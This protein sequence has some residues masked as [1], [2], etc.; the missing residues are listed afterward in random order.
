MSGTAKKKFLVLFLAP[1]QVLQDWAKTDPETR[2]GAEEKMRADWQRWMGEHASMILTTEAGGRTKKL[3]AAGV[4]DFNN[5]IMLYSTVEAESHEQ[6]AKAF[7]NHPHL[8]IPQ[9]T[10]QVMEV[11]SMG[12]MA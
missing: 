8:S 7:A 5:D 12:G 10:I 1:S 11:R 4:S 9:S 6:A 2:K 3:S